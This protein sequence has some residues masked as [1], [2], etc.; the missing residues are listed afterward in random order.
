ML[1]FVLILLIQSI[2]G[3]KLILHAGAGH[4]IGTT[5]VVISPIN[6]PYTIELYDVDDTLICVNEFNEMSVT[7]VDDVCK[8]SYVENLNGVYVVTM[9]HPDNEYG[10]VEAHLI[11]NGRKTIENIPG[12]CPN[13]SQWRCDQAPTQPPTTTQPPTPA[14]TPGPPTIPPVVP[15]ATAPIYYNIR[16]VYNYYYSSDN[17]NSNII[18]FLFLI[19]F[20]YYLYANINITTTY[21]FHTPRKIK[22]YNDKNNIRY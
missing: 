20:G 13:G 12:T 15:N 19:L 21:K 5:Q 7:D 4:Q 10:T 3:R 17:N 22:Y 9:Q 18:V 16:Y 8:S 6:G 11:V 2:H 14:P 1:W